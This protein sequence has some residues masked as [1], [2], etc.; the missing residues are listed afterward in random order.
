MT[1]PVQAAELVWESSGDVEIIDP[2]N[3][4]LSTDGLFDDDFDLGASN[5]DFN[6]SGNPATSVGFDLGFGKLEDF[7]GID[8]TELDLDIDDIA[9]E[10]SAIKTTLNLSSRTEVS[11]DWEFLTNETSDDLSGRPF[12]DYG[13]FFLGQKITKLADW[14]NA[15]Q[16]TCDFGFDHCTE[17]GNKTR[18]LDPGSY[19]LGFGV[20][21]IDDFVVTSALRISSFTLTPISHFGK[22]WDIDAAISS[23]AKIASG[24]DVPSVEI[25]PKE[26]LS[27]QGAFSQQNNTIHL[28]Q[29]LLETGNSQAIISVLLEELGHYLDGKLNPND[30]PGD[31]GR[32][33]ATVVQGI[34]L[35]PLERESLAMEDDR[36]LLN[37]KGETFIIEQSLNDIIGTAGRDIITG[38]SQGDRIIGR[39]GA[40]IITGGGGNDLFVYQNIRD[41]G[42]TIK[43]FE[44]GKDQLDLTLVL[45]GFGYTGFNPLADGY[46]KLNGCG[47]FRNED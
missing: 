1:T 5:G 20:I 34:K 15:N 38:T 13:F 18:T 41:A 11:F 32:L 9:Y 17:T 3:L 42:D 2:N 22:Y 4:Q 33:F 29:Q 37:F 21:D 19:T 45:Q 47:S 25:L 39:A 30:T 40:D 12:N 8:V 36:T 28:S 7:L 23:L 31:E 44:I 46:I 26:I 6:F 35:T 10:G 16:T 27:A 24:Q 43:D 14:T